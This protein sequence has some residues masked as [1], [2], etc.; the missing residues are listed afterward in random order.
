MRSVFIDKNLQEQFDR[1]GYVKINSDCLEQIDL[2]QKKIYELRPSDNFRAEQ[3]MTIGKQDFHCTFFDSNFEYR[4]QTMEIINDFYK[5][6]LNT[7]LIDYKII[8]ANVFIKHA[9]R[10]YLAPHQNLTVVD[11]SKYSSISLWCP[12]VD[13]CKANGTMVVVPGSHKKFVRYRSTNVCWPLLDLF[14]DYTSPFFKIIDV[15]K[16]EMLVIDDT[17]IHGTTNN[18][19]QEERFVFHAVAV[20]EEA[21]LIYPEINGDDVTIYRVPE[22]FWQYY[23]PGEN[24]SGLEIVEKKHYKFKALNNEEFVEELKS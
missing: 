24:P 3:K 9:Q 22:S 21:E 7:Y 6:V 10:G 20:P 13:T 18:V 12:A 16:G 2:Y 1:D 11:E 4:M 15:K 23:Q 14:K 8:Q 19:S 5:S 17:L